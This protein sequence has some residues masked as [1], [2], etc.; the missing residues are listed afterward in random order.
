MMIEFEWDDHKF[1]SLEITLIG[2]VYMNMQV[3]IIVSE[4]F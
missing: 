2:Y 4:L 3:Y 1:L